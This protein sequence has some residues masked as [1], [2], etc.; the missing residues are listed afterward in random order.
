MI[1]N[2]GP[3]E[4]RL[5]FR[6]RELFPGTERLRQQAGGVARLI[7]TELPLAALGVVL[8]HNGERPLGA[9]TIV[10][11]V[12]AGVSRQGGEAEDKGKERAGGVC[13]PPFPRDGKHPC[14]THCGP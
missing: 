13:K 8:S 9:G 7:G 4:G 12:R 5:E 2:L 14:R 3:R 1:S 6:T 11:A 10:R